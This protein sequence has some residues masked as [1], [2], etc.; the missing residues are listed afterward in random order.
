MLCHPE[1]GGVCES[2]RVGFVE[3]LTYKG[4]FGGEG[5]DSGSGGFSV[6]REGGGSKAEGDTQKSINDMETE[7][8]PTGI[9]ED[10]GMGD[11]AGGDGG[12]VGGVGRGGGGP[13]RGGGEIAVLFCSPMGDCEALG[14]CDA[15][16]HVLLAGVNKDPVSCRE[17]VH[18]PNGGGWQLAVDGEVNA[19]CEGQVVGLVDGPM[20][21]GSGGG[22]NVM[23]AKWVFR[24]GVGA[25]GSVVEG[26]RIVGRGFEDGSFYDLRETCAPVSGLPAVRAALSCASGRSY[27][28][29]QDDCVAAFLNGKLFDEVYMEVPEGFGVS[30][31][32]R[33]A[34]V[35]KLE[36]AICGLRMG[37]ER[38]CGAFTGF[39]IELGFGSGDHDPCLFIYN[40]PGIEVV[41][42]LYVDDILKMSNSRAKLLE[43]EQ[44]LQAGFGTRCMGE[45][46]EYL[47]IKIMRDKENKNIMLNQTKFI[48]KMLIKFGYEHAK[49]QVTPMTTNQVQNRERR[50][51]EGETENDQVVTPTKYRGAVG[52]LMYLA[53]CTRPDVLYAV[54]MLSGHQ[55]DPTRHEWR[56]VDRVFGYLQGTRHFSLTY[57]G[58]KDGLEACSDAGLADCGGS[59]TTCG[60][61]AQLCGDPIA[62]KAQGRG[63]VALSTCQAE[64]VAVSEACRELI[65]MTMSLKNFAHGIGAP[66][67]LYCD[68]MAAVS[69]TKTEGG[70][71][72]EHLTEIGEHYVRECAKRGLV[73]VVWVPSKSQ[74][75]D[76]FA[77]PLP[78]STHEHLTNILL[79][80]FSSVTGGQ[81]PAGG[82]QWDVE[83][84]EPDV[85]LPSAILVLV[86]DTVNQTLY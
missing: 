70:V 72:L 75:A 39:M 12:E 3:R 73:V 2:G 29:R 24:A 85:F 37:P 20:I 46:K 11:I 77:R 22:P 62:W 78:R 82:E 32:E 43:I 80:V 17:A 47:G 84:D 9:S 45:P 28:M 58:L 63:C 35:F 60:W 36:R 50:E 30:D 16:Y 27:E 55:L 51:R 40:E 21:G 18:G 79:G 59:P 31:G 34:R 6:E 64:C 14:D 13:G 67:K 1:S 56:V 15:G 41:V 66:V 7:G 86:K 65:A 26:A 57:R 81:P 74:L 10:S 38:W 52:T 61:V 49:S 8:E 23:D 19:I 69:S 54:N 4:E 76:I 53:M 44:K 68:G 25:D 5:S 71:K 48:E 33:G 42:V 83:G